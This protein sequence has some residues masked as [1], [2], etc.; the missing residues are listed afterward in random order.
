MGRCW[1]D[2]EGARG[3]ADDG[4]TLGEE[5]GREGVSTKRRSSSLLYHC[6][7]PA[8]PLPRSERR[9]PLV[10]LL[11]RTLPPPPPLASPPSSLHYTSSFGSS[12]LYLCEEDL[13]VSE[14]VLLP[15]RPQIP[16]AYVMKEERGEKECRRFVV[17]SHRREELDEIG[18]KRASSCAFVT[19]SASG[20]QCEH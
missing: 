7:L 18:V 11:A 8:Q 17:V 5:E 16:V 2:S 4:P 14:T 1:P 19:Q 10:R 13:R 20:T 15:S 3:N 12:S 9:V 6:F